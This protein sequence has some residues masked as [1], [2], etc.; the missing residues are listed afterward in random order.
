MN[1]FIT[2]LRIAELVV[3]GEPDPDMGE[4]VKAVG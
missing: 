3:I 2:H 4:A 1:L